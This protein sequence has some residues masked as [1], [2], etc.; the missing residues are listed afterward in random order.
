MTCR[1]C[2][3]AHVAVVMGERMIVAGL[4]PA[5]RGAAANVALRIL[6]LVVVIVLA[7]VAITM[8]R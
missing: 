2:G 6:G 5:A 7:A 4:A 8:W 1:S 3:T